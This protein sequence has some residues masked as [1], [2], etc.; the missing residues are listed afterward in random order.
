MNVEMIQEL[1]LEEVVEAITSL[2]KGKAPSRNGLSTWFFKKNMEEIA[3]MLL[4]AFQAMLSMVLTSDIINKGMITL[5]PKFGNHSKLGNWRPIT[6]LGSIHKTLAK[7]LVRRIQVYLPIMIKPNQI[8]FV[9]GR[10]ILDNNLLA[11][12]LFEWV[13]ESEQDLVLLLLDFEKT[14]D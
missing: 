2:P 3:P 13:V 5:I 4:L 12:E 9:M 11:Q 10:S 8:G 14:F 1:T 6:L 7:I